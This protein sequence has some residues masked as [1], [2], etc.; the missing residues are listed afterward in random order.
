MAG[1]VVFR[2]EAPIAAFGEIAVGV[3][4]GTHRRPSVSGILG[5]VSAALGLPRDAPEHE[6]LARH[7]RVAT[8]L[9]GLGAPL[10][11]F[12]TAQTPPERKGRRF[13]TRRDELAD[14]LD[15]ATIISRRDHWTDA[16]FTVAMWPN[17]DPASA[18]DAEMIAKAM[19]RPRW[20]PY[21]G[22]RACALSRPLAA[23]VVQA[24]TLS[25]AFEAWDTAERAARA[26]AGW[27]AHTVGDALAV[28]ESFAP[29]GD[30]A[31]AFEGLVA[32]RREF[33]PDRL[34]S[35]ARW[36]FDMR[37]EVLAHGAARASGPTP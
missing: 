12:H 37:T 31:A 2:L 35:R 33:R 14:P 23:R 20:T 16:A 15:L 34:V 8:R 4:R 3:H 25:Q 19:S 7:W 27:N 5:L 24:E 29:G 11:D 28:D 6:A 21:A 18:P 1:V 9:D 32:E 22:R 13:A 26:R 10:A 36:Q 30:L 17:G